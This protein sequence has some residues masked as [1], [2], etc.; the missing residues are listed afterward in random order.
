VL[1]IA[2]IFLP[3]DFDANYYLMVQKVESDCLELRSRFD[4]WTFALKKVMMWKLNNSIRLNSQSRFLIGKR[5]ILTGLV[6]VLD[7]A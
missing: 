1:T 3:A 6:K 2:R 4:I 7:S 5:E